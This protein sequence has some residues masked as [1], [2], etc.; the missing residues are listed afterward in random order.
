MPISEIE[1]DLNLY[2]LRVNVWNNVLVKSELLVR[3]SKMFEKMVMF[4]EA[5]ITEWTFVRL[6]S[7][8]HSKVAQKVIA[9]SKGLEAVVKCTPEVLRSRVH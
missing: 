5:L 8:M 7:R 2:G 6:V 4:S 1:S 3:A 9:T